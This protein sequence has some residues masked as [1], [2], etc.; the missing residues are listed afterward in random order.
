[1]AAQALAG[2]VGGSDQAFYQGKLTTMRYFFHYELPKAKGLAER[3]A[4]DDGL[5]ARMDAR[6]FSD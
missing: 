4:E 5:T 1:V 2:G 6:L 3:L